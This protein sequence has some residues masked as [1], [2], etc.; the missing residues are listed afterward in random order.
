MINEMEVKEFLKLNLI[1]NIRLDKF[2]KYF[3]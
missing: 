1:Q 2:K 3:L